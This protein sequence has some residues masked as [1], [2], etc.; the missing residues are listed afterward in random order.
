MSVTHAVFAPSKSDTWANCAGAL[1]LAKDLPAE[2]PSIYA[3]SGTLTHQIGHMMLLGEGNYPGL[4]ATVEV[5][6]FKFTIDEERLARARAYADAVKARGGV[7]FYEV[8]LKLKPVY[9]FD[10]DDGHADAVVA[11]VEERRLEVHDLKDGVTPVEPDTNQCIIYAGAAMFQYAFLAEWQEI[12]VY[13]HQPKVRPEP[14]AKVFTRAELWKELA[15]IGTAA[16]RAERMLNGMEPLEFNPGEKQCRWCPARGVCCARADSFN[17]QFMGD[18]PNAMIT[19]THTLTDADL[20]SLLNKRAAIEAAFE[21]WAAEALNRARLGGTIPGWK[22]AQGRAG[23]R[24]WR[25]EQFAERVLNAALA[26]NA[27]KRTLIGPPEA[28][29]QLKKARPDIWSELSS[30][31]ERPEGQLTLV[32]EADFRP[33]VAVN[34]PEFA[35]L[36]EQPDLIGAI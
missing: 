27:Y 19:A 34:I 7:Q 1:A 17:S 35:N 11:L 14:A 6:G 31:V 28:E 36:D 20:A 4:Y 15:R 13:I 22:I 5:D 26:G 33:A 23:N 3:A 32:P 2:P 18:L 24:K 30:N 29:K 8:G 21:Q 9:G 12:A 25:D 10:Q 16:Q